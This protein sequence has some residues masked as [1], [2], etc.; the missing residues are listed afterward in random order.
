MAEYGTAEVE[1]DDGE[2]VV[3][4]ARERF[5][6]AD[7]VD[8]D[9]RAEARR[10]TLF[11]YVPGKQWPDEIKSQRVA[12]KEPC[13][14]FNQLKQFVHQVVND[15]RQNRPGIRVHPAGG[16]ASEEVAE[17]IQDLIRGIEYESKAEAAYDNGFT[18]AVV[19]GR[20]YWRVVSEY[21]GPTDFTQRLCIKPIADAAAV[22]LD[23]EYQEPDGSDRGWAFVVERMTREEFKRQWPGQDP[24]SWQDVDS[25]WVDGEDYVYVADYY[26]RVCTTRK[27]VQMSDGA[28]G[29]KDELPKALPA[30]VAIVAERDADSYSVEWYK[31]CGGPKPLAKYEWPGTIIPIICVPGDETIVDGKRVFQGLIR[32]ARDSQTMFNFGMTQQAVHLALTPRAPWLAAEGQITGYENIWKDANVKNFSVLPYKPTSIDGHPVP[33]PQ[34]TAP[35][36]PDA[37]WINW[38]MQMTGLIKS[39]IGMYQNSL[40]ERSDEK[41]GR[42]IIAREKQGD[43]A[44]FHYFD[45]LSRAIALTGRVI[46]EVLPTFYDTQRIVHTIG[47]DD[48]RKTVTI[49]EPVMGVDGALEAIKRNDITVGEYSVTVEAGPG[50][51]TKRQETAESLM[52]FVQAF[53]PAG[54]VAGDLIAKAMDWPDKDVIAERLK[55]A[56][57]PA[58]Q[59]AEAAKEE[60]GGKPLPPAVAMKMAQL[61]GRLQEAEQVMQQQH[62]ELQQAQSGTAEKMQA[63]QLKAESDKQLAAQKA[64]LDAEAAAAQAERDAITERV[65]AEAQAQAAI[66]KAHIDAAAKVEVA[67][68][69]AQA[70]CA[71]EAENRAALPENQPE[72]QTALSEVAQG[73]Q[74]VAQAIGQQSQALAA[75]AEAAL[76]E[77]ESVL[78]MDDAGMP[79]RSVSRAVRNKPTVQ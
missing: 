43:N 7:S 71:I 51:A 16:Q 28:K 39:T 32:Q 33:P 6:H 74:M 9:N 29:W 58:I 4:E 73:M 66:E 60:N 64:A 75:V 76:A 69:D 54:Q 62:Q 1:I 17:V 47:K 2:E 55:L 78:E 72:A 15:Q 57:P 24:A 14:E 12:W 34:R 13:L 23:L 68:I 18:G 3:K 49:N 65:R 56:L 21:T 52:S 37:G 5:E 25:R 50:Y 46:V 10:D 35:S 42:A 31:V 8:R 20:G 27:L 11:V 59:Q 22:Y 48:T 36:M 26:R 63:A 38:S 30:G 40:G 70:K 19:G 45:N 53:P 41:S 67:R 79:T 77:R 61:S 44:T